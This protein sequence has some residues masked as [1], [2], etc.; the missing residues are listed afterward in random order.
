MFSA[1]FHMTRLGP[2][3]LKIEFFYYFLSTN[4][5]PGKNP[6]LSSDTDRKLRLNFSLWRGAL[7]A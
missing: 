2:F 3:N 4:L 5:F 7:S 1:D 6:T